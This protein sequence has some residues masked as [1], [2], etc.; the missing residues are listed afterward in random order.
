MDLIFGSIERAFDL[1]R[2]R[3]PWL[4]LLLATLGWLAATA[5]F[6]WYTRLGSSGEASQAVQW[7]S[8]AFLVSPPLLLLLIVG[9]R[10]IAGVPP[11]AW[12]LGFT[13][14]TVVSVVFGVVYAGS[15][16]S[17][18]YGWVASLWSFLYVQMFAVVVASV[19]ELVR[20][21]RHG[22]GG[23][24]HPDDERRARRRLLQVKLL[25]AAVGLVVVLRHLRPDGFLDRLGETGDLPLGDSGVRVADIAVLLVPLLG[26]ALFV[27][28]RWTARVAALAT[29]LTVALA[30][31]AL[32]ARQRA[33]TALQYWWLVTTVLYLLLKAANRP[34][35][36]AWP[37]PAPAPPEIPPAQATRPDRT[38]ADLGW[39]AA[40]VL[41]TV[42]SC[43][44][45]G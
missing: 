7:S 10:G 11:V 39:I 20:R 38:A 17:G 3:V 16:H 23:H 24:R 21:R 32:P 43:C 37:R 15:R 14:L 1:L 33:D 45:A 26:L 29:A 44:G 25:T 22:P 4:G 13:S 35:W 19:D 12:P 6:V 2:Q 36:A 42:L 40:S 5:A 41:V 30:L 28:H 34:Y 27:R 31:F 18:G 9:I 8:I